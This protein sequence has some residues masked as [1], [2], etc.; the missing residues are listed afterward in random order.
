V[1][2]KTTLKADRP[3]HWTEELALQFVQHQK[4][5]TTRKSVTRFLRLF[6]RR[7]DYLITKEFPEFFAYAEENRKI[8]ETRRS[9][10]SK[11]RETS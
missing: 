5:M 4:C 8:L 7:E 10:S 1:I 6:A 9:P 3:A 11:P 2:S